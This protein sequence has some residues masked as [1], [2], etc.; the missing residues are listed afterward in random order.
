MIVTKHVVDVGHLAV[1][2]APVLVAGGA[3]QPLVAGRALEA[4]LVPL[5]AAGQLLLSRVNCLEAHAAFVG[6]LIVFLNDHFN[7]EQNVFDDSHVT[8]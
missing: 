7:L 3:V 5:E 4:A 8:R 6:Q 1:E 2:A